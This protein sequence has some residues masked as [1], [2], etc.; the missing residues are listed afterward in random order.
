MLR[1]LLVTARFVKRVSN[2]LSQYARWSISYLFAARKIDAKAMQHPDVLTGNYKLNKLVISVLVINQRL[3]ASI[4][5][6]QFPLF[7]KG[8]TK[9]VLAKCRFQRMVNVEL[10]FRFDEHISTNVLQLTGS[11]LW[12][13]TFLKIS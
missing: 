8:A 6:S 9:F 12:K 7:H 5:G 13:Q 1:F 3:H 4:D 10:D 2:M 11:G